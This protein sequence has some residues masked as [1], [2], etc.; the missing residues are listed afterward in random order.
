MIAT[1]A[2][3]RAAGDAVPVT[4]APTEPR[5]V[6][7]L[8]LAALVCAF[9]IRVAIGLTDDAPSTDET[10]Y[11]R[12]GVSLVE[13][14]GFER[15]G[16][17]E[18]HFPPL[19]PA[20]LGL[21]SLVFDDAHT[22]AVWLTILAGTAVVVPLSLLARR[23]GGA[24]AGV[25]AAWIAALAPA[26]ATSP[27][28]RGAGSEATYALLVVLALWWVVDAADHRGRARG[29]RV[30]A[31]GVA[32][33]L[34]YLTR[35]EGLFVG[36]PLGIAVVVLARRRGDGAADGDEA[37]P[38]RLR[39]V[40]LV[41]AF[42]VPIL[43]CVAP[44]AA[45][46]H[47]NTGRW[48]LTAKTQD[49]S[50]EA[51]QAVARADRQ[52]RD[53]VLYALDETGYGFSTER[54]SLPA[55]ALD[56]PGGYVVV[57]RSNV[58]ELAQALVNPTAGQLLAWLL[59]PLPVWGLVG[60]GLWRYRRSRPIQLLVA[61]AALP[62]ATSLVFFVQPRYLMAA[63]TL[64]VVPAAVALAG[65]AGNVRRW[66][67]AGVVVLLLLSS[68]QAFEGPGGWWHPADH[69][70]QRDAGE[71]LA[72]HTDADDPVMTRSMIVGYYAER[73]TL[74]I[75]YADLDRIVDFGRHYGAQYLV[76]DWYTVKRLRP[77]MRELQTDDEVPGLRLVHEVTRE[78]R[79]TRIFAFDPAPPKDVPMG[80][81]LGFVG[82]G[83]A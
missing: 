45:Y 57:L 15:D 12:S 2:P 30:V 51:W 53:R 16:H 62:V 3:E 81:S 7:W 11:L 67:T 18:L 19:V 65:F 52:A 28:N 35:P 46:L 50:I 13:G 41:A 66:L 44:Y 55:L 9:G 78:G 76:V 61:V 43:L 40:A 56:D 8:L 80:P 68:V 10:A 27:T 36:V 37:G 32:V 74:A 1:V 70:D 64:A 79:T 31:A 75:P 5:R 39:S 48:Q 69:T 49:A 22:G 23:V 73:P 72:A 63:A 38:S 83:T 71:W 4:A 25:A 29:W 60:L 59:L 47:G 26:V 77:Q 82:D 14:D 6:G 20:L 17:P 42:V 34:A 21:G 24:A 58:A 33:G 54:T